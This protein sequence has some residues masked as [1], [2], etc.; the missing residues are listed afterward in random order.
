[1]IGLKRLAL[2]SSLAIAAC[3]TMP[4]QSATIS[5]KLVGTWRLVSVENYSDGLPVAYPYGRNPVGLLIYDR[6]GHMAIQIM[7]TPHPGVAS[8]DDRR[9]TPEEKIALFDAYTAYFGTYTVDVER[10]VI[11]HRVEGDIADVYVGKNQAR[12][13][14]LAG[15]SLVLKPAWQVDGRAWEGRRV[16]ERVQ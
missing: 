13:F 11:T 15:D 16:F 3:T 6:T 1:M 9:I 14:E 8:G 5:D 7:A 10:A 4:M 2:A 12:P